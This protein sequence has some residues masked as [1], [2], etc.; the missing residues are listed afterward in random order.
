MTLSELN[1]LQGLLA[2]PALFVLAGFVLFWGW[3][4]DR[5]EAW[6]TA[7]RRNGGD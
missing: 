5:A 3:L 7:R 1:N 6:W 2:G 4:L